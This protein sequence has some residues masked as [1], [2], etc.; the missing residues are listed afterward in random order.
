MSGADGASRTQRDSGER[1]AVLLRSAALRSLVVGASDAIY[2]HEPERARMWQVFAATLSGQRPYR[3][4][5]FT[6]KDARRGIATVRAAP[7]TEHTRVVGV[8]AV[9]R[10]VTEEHRL[11]AGAVRRETIV[12][13]VRDS[14]SGIAPEH[15]PHIFNSFHTTKP[16]GI[17]TGLGLSIS[18]GIVRGHDG[19]LRVQSERG[20]GALFEV[21]LPVV[22]PPVPVP[23]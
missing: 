9:V 8:L 17:G 4:L 21:I 13:G 20:A 5:H 6:R 3:E 7:I 10:D 18:D 12:V 2:V 14:G 1:P 16:R 19:T 22:S 15:L 23:V 11:V